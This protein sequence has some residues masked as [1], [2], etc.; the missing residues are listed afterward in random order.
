M[1]YEKNL[2]ALDINKKNIKEKIQQTDFD[3]KLV[4]VYES[5]I[6]GSYTIRAKKPGGEYSFLLHSAVDPVEQAFQWVKKIDL[7]KNYFC[8][9]IG[10]GFGY[11]VRELRKKQ[12]S[13]GQ[14]LIIE[15]RPDLF[16]AALIHADVSDILSDSNIEII[17]ADNDLRDNLYKFCMRKLYKIK[18][19]EVF[20]SPG[21]KHIIE[22]DILYYINT[23]IETI[24]LSF[25]NL[26]NS[27]RDSLVG[28]KNIFSNYLHIA[29]SPLLKNMKDK[30]NNIPAIIVSAGPSLDKNFRLLKNIKGKAIIL[31][32][33]TC[34]KKLL[35]ESIYPD[36]VFNVERDREM[37]DIYFRDIEIPSSVILVADAVTDTMVLDTWKSKKIIVARSTTDAE[38]WLAEK[39]DNIM[40]Y[41]VGSS[42]AHMML[43]F[44]ECLGCKN[45]ILVGQDLAYGEDGANHAKSTIYDKGSKEYKQDI[46]EGF[47]RDYGKDRIKVKG[48]YDDFV[49]TTKVWNVWLKWFELKAAKGS[50]KLINCTEGGAYIENTEII[51]LEE[52]LRK[53]CNSEDQLFINDLLEREEENRSVE[54]RLKSIKDFIKSQLDILNDTEDEM[55]KLLD[56]CKDFIEKHRNSGMEEKDAK[57]VFDHINGM[58]AKLPV[59][60]RI[61]GFIV[62]ALRAFNYQK[63]MDFV[64]LENM[65]M[66]LEWVNIQIDFFDNL[67]ATLKPTII[68]FKE[69]YDNLRY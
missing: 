53:Y 34:L 9:V 48:N 32:A 42:V 35:D 21:Y 15:P 27:P 37:Y 10:F 13:H 55:I 51:T 61:F 23:V 26:G 19:I 11:Y 22:N 68:I 43:G 40:T 59:K 49:L 33:A 50:F 14:I 5:S 36:F 29:K 54:Q 1:Y 7:S 62:Q 58:R 25:F 18:E 28:I 24:R 12:L 57:I 56:Y 16:K 17:F 6:K 45:I 47:E 41:D 66:F 67:L 2:A 69:G 3:G 63:D 64:K 39:V 52:G 20:Q 44:A 30:L 8:L 4:S 65:K 38:N 31:C 60:C 46:N